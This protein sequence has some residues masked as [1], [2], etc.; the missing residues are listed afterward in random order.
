MFF[1]KLIW[2]IWNEFLEIGW[3][4]DLHGKMNLNLSEKKTVW[5]VELVFYFL[6]YVFCFV[7]RPEQKSII[8]QHD[9]L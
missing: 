6:V 1:L 3:H 4:S 8:E 7:D 2:K 5:T 9:L